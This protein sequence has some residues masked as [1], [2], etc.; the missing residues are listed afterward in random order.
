MASP[1]L[2]VILTGHDLG[3]SA[4]VTR[5]T[6]SINRLQASVIALAKKLLFITGA[7]LIAVGALAVKMA[8][9]FQTAFTEVTTL[10]DLPLEA[11]NSLRKG[12]LA[13]SAEM[14]FG[15]VE[16]TK[17]LYQAISA[18]VAPGNAIDF[19]RENA[20]LAV[21]GVTDLKTAVDLTTTVMNAWGL[22]ASELTSV[23]DALFTTVRLGKTTIDELGAA[24]FNVAP[25]AAQAGVSIDQVGAALASMTAQGTPTS[26]A[27]TQLRMAILALLA[28]TKRQIS[29]ALELGFTYD[30]TKLATEGMQSVFE[31]LI[32]ATG[33]SETKLRRLLG[34]VEAVLAVLQLMGPQAQLFTDNLAAMAEKGGAAQ[35]AFEKMN[36]TFERQLAILKA[37]LGRAMIEIGSVILPKLTAGVVALT[38][39]LG[40]ALPAAGKRARDTFTEWKPVLIETG[41]VL[42]DLTDALTTF[43]NWILGNQKALVFAIVAIGAAFAWAL[44]GGPLIVGLGAIIL[45]ISIFRADLEKLGE[46]ALRA[47]IKILELTISGKQGLIDLQNTVSLGL[48]PALGKLFDQELF[49]ARGQNA[50]KRTLAASEAQLASLGRE[51]AGNRF[52]DLIAAQ[53]GGAVVSLDQL[54]RAFLN[55][56]ATGNAMAAQQAA[57]QLALVPPEL[58]GMDLLRAVER[59]SGIGAVTTPPIVFTPPPAL[60]PGSGTEIG[61]ELAKEIEEKLTERER[62]EKAGGVIAKLI[63]DGLRSGKLD[64]RAAV[65]ILLDVFDKIPPKFRDTLNEA[66][67]ALRSFEDGLQR[68]SQIFEDAME[69]GIVTFSQVAELLSLGADDMARDFL[70]A[71]EGKSSEIGAAI[72]QHAQE[73]AAEAARE[74]AEAFVEEFNAGLGDLGSAIGSAI[75]TLRGLFRQETVESAQNELILINKKLQLLAIEEEIASRIGAIREMFAALILANEEKIA[76]TQE[77]ISD[78][79][80]KAAGF[81]SEIADATSR[82][83]DLTREISSLVSDAA[84]AAAI[85]GETVAGIDSVD[86]TSLAD[87]ARALQDAREGGI[88]ITVAQDALDSLH[89][90]AAEAARIL[91]RAI[92]GVSAEDPTLVDAAQRVADLRKFRPG[93]GA[94]IAAE[95]ALAEA[96][97]E[98]LGKVAAA[99]ENLAEVE[100]IAATKLEAAEE[101]F[102]EAEAAN[103]AARLEAEKALKA[104]ELIL[105]D[106]E[107][108]H[109]DVIAQLVIEEKVLRNLEAVRDDLIVSEE[110]LIGVEEERLKASIE[111]ADA[112]RDEIDAMEEAERIRQLQIRAIEIQVLLA[113]DLLLTNEELNQQLIDEIENINL[114]RDTLGNLEDDTFTAID[115]LNLL[116]LGFEALAQQ[117]LKI[118]AGLAS[119]GGVVGVASAAGTGGLAGAQVNYI[120]QVVI[121]QG[122]ENQGLAAL[123][124]VVG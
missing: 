112:L 22:A 82:I 90:E 34:S 32:E 2:K 114:L 104:E 37:E 36:E 88:E 17:A 122:T 99:A 49:A 117:I 63:A 5:V 16:A 11:I 42:K 72:F 95:A 89:D 4:V 38:A 98:H 57:F 9:S 86:A 68:T 29:A 118:L 27:T 107:I 116:A 46:T 78:L 106:L 113:N 111:Q 40:T 66:A 96:E 103:L 41:G 91:G 19:L 52:G 51:A 81:A 77:R 24:L 109:A 124:N 74:A 64:M 85:L 54:N 44:P 67:S 30:K 15:A 79:T 102:R 119:A 26:V 12:V 55:V 25:I 94:L 13:L 62:W 87:L 45:T 18:G 65:D 58:T 10:V 3:A 39:W 59:Q 48:I 121:N 110:F 1:K 100:V 93:S 20:K 69:T 61:A 84:A 70:R 23:N 35:T 6:A 115:A 108:A 120:D 76:A 80:E 97:A 8:A 31:D 123:G 71:I 43:G 28:P 47:K 7:A 60:S 53:A 50:L 105:I 14:G 73:A 92:A 56:L 21:G 101:A 83:A 33:G 75:G